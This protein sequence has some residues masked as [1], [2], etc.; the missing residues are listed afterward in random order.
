MP[1]YYNADPNDADRQFRVTVSIGIATTVPS[2][3]Q[4]PSQLVA[5]AD[6]AL[7]QAKDAGRNRVHCIPLTG[8]RS[9]TEQP[10]PHL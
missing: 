5:T 3:D 2:I 6:A 9:S 10:Q 7:Y 1:I 8:L 4:P